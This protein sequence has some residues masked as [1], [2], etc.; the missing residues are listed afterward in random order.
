[1]TNA[2]DARGDSRI[3][4]AD[5]R[6]RLRPGSWIAAAAILVFLAMIVK[7]AATNANMHW[8][9]VRHYFF[10]SAILSGLLLSLELTAVGM[11]LGVALGLV[12]A[13]MRL[14]GNPVLRAVSYGY[15]WIFRGTPLLVQLLFWYFLAAVLP[16]VGIGVPFGPTFTDWSTNSLISKFTAAI[17]G[18][19][20]NEAAFS[21]E[22][23]RGGIQS[24][25]G[26]QREAADAL[27]LTPG[28]RMRK[29][30]L[31]QSMAFVIPPL[32]NQVISMLKNTSLVI[33]IALPELLTS[34]QNIYSQN[35][36]QI[37]LLVVACGWYLI[38]FAVLCLVQ[39][40]IERRFSRGHAAYRRRPRLLKA[41][42]VERDPA[43]RD[44]PGQETH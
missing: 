22:V 31:P 9:V 40:Y 28:Q 17:L 34:V 39:L 44:E 11:L 20:L 32:G 23:I 26:G 21:S 19:A 16:H 8:D 30:I 35:F 13:V 5:A 43:G 36:L 2:V 6:H 12:L 33:V 24:V 1:M 10:N 25:D 4:P 18:L 15:G 14:S 37:P 27:G 42:T 7:G 41:D 29:I 3:E 38:A